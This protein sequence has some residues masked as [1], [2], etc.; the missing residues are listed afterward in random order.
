MAKPRFTA[1]EDSALTYK[2]NLAMRILNR[3]APRLL[4]TSIP[5][6]ER[7]SNAYTWY[8][9]LREV[10]ASLCR[11]LCGEIDSDYSNWGSRDIEVI[12]KALVS[13]ASRLLKENIKLN[14]IG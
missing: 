4:N 7:V 3:V 14:V 5:L 10:D 6:S 12:A 1:S 13:Y 11:D 9:F 8:V 2:Y